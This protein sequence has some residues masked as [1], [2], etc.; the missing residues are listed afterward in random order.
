MI[1]NT[2][3]K[4]KNSPDRRDAVR[5]IDYKMITKMTNDYNYEFFKKFSKRGLQFLETYANI[6][7]RNIK[8]GRRQVSPV[9]VALRRVNTML[10]ALELSQI[11]DRGAIIPI[12]LSCSQPG[13][14]TQIIFFGG[15]GKMKRAAI[16][17]KYEY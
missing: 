11:P 2:R 4:R 13:E 10:N 6:N 14:V 9:P 15:L 7:A 8:S 16:N 12:R 17:I 5:G 3:I 1:N